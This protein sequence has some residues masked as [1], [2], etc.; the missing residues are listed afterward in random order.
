[1]SIGNPKKAVAALMPET[2]RTPEGLEVKPMTLAM[3]AALERIASPLVTGKPV[4]DTA[5]L[6]PSLYLLTHGADRIFAGN[7]TALAFAWA[8]TMPVTVVANI[9]SACEAQMRTVMDVMPEPQKKK[10]AETTDGS[11]RRSTPPRKTTGGATAKS[12]GKSR[13]RR[14]CCSDARSGLKP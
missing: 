10:P 4:K 9:R 14:S 3:Y 11:P 6:L 1:M 5:E 13:S 7:L 2:F 12:C 8:D